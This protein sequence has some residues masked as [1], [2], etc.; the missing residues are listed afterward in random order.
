MAAGPTLASSYTS[1]GMS[2]TGATTITTLGTIVTGVWNGTD[3]AVADGG[4]GSSTAPAARTALGLAIGTD[5]QAQ[6][7]TL[8]AVAGGTYAG[9]DSIV[10]VGTIAA[11]AWDGTD[12]PVTAGGTGSSTA[13]GAR[14]N[15]G[16]YG[17]GDTPSFATSVTIT[18][19]SGGLFLPDAGGDH[20]GKLVMQQNVGSNLTFT[21]PWNVNATFAATNI[22]QSWTAG[23]SFYTGNL[24]V[25]DTGNSHAYAFVSAGDDAANRNITIPLLSQNA[26]FSFIDFAQTWSAIQ[27]HSADIITSGATTDIIIGTAGG[28]LQ[29]K[30]GSN[31]TCGVA[32]LSAGT[33]TVSTT[34]VTANSRIFLTGQ[35]TSGTIG[36]LTVS[37]RNAA[38]DFTITGL[39]TDTRDVAWF[40]VEPAPFVPVFLL[41]ARFRRRK[42][43]RLAA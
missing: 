33:V 7:A 1:A 32:T 40:I 31:A 29:V 18:G 30:E 19:A 10:T 28:G 35:N 21:L 36:E 41:L 16:A 23:Q 37:A 27:T 11:G 9:D 3:I 38:Q 4:T 25:N 6:D 20:T 8:A 17:S 26:T 13:A 15:L 42:R 12:V 22:G 39:A 24:K 14:T 43:L 5:V 34:K 2:P